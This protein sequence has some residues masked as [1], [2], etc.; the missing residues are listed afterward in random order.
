MIRV[1]VWPKTPTITSFFVILFPQQNRSHIVKIAKSWK[2]GCCCYFV[3]N[4]LIPLDLLLTLNKLLLSL[5]WVFFFRCP[6]HFRSWCTGRGRDTYAKLINLVQIRV[7]SFLLRAL[8]LYL[9]VFRRCRPFHVFSV[10]N[11]HWKKFPSATQTA[12][13]THTYGVRNRTKQRW[14][15]RRRAKNSAF[16]SVFY[17]FYIRKWIRSD[18]MDTKHRRQEKSEEEKQRNWSENIRMLLRNRFDLSLYLSIFINGDA[19]EVYYNK[20]QLNSRESHRDCMREAH[21]Q[22]HTYGTIFSVK[23]IQNTLFFEST[24]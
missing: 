17:E 14:Y 12:S 2:F 19:N 16:S 22:D 5:L 8:S 6:F 4:H 13:T 15:F 10:I 1:Y 3:N 20:W 7:R 9:F 18:N 21:T 24:L 23:Y 11:F